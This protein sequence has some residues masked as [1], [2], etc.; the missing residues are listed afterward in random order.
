PDPIGSGPALQFPVQGLLY[1]DGVVYGV[2]NSD[3]YAFDPATGDR[4]D[5]S[6]TKSTYGGMGYANMVW[7]ASRAVVWAVGTAAPFVGSIVNLENGRRESIY[8]DTGREEHGDAAV[9]VSVYPDAHSV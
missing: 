1:H 7:D 9:L 8:S 6:Y 3:L 4:H 2:S 5:A